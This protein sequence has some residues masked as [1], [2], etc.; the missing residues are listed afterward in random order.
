MYK[1][2]TMSVRKETYIVLGFKFD[3]EFTEDYWEKDFR[4]ETEYFGKNDNGKIMFI[5]D[6][7]NGNYTFFG[8]IIELGTKGEWYKDQVQ[9]IDLNTSSTDEIVKTFKQYYPESTLQA[10]DVKLY[11]LPH[12]V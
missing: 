8:Q 12:Y 9:E 11:Y 2:R 5:T 1:L 3:S 10:E 6:G 4:D 7:M